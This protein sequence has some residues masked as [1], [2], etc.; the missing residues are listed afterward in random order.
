MPDQLTFPPTLKPAGPFLFQ[1]NF[2]FG[3]SPAEEKAGMPERTENVGSIEVAG[4]CG[5]R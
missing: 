4:E 3:S 2:T 1:A 5:R